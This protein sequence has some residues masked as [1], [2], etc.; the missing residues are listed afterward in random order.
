MAKFIAENIDKEKKLVDRIINNLHK[1]ENAYITIFVAH[2]SKSNYLLD[3]LL[4]NAEILFEEYKPATLDS[5]ELSFFDQHED[6]II[7]AVLPA[8]QNSV[9]EERSK[10]L[11]EK[12]KREDVRKESKQDFEEDKVN[13]TSELARELRR[14]IKTVEVMGLVIK[15]RAGSLDKNRLEHLFEQGLKVHLRILSSFFEIIK[16][17]NFEDDFVDFITERL[18]HIIKS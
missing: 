5:Q 17:K 8:Y 3:E 10:L 12:A 15:N 14:S 13:E 4:L 6:K 9:G 11:V 1:D 2:H 7:K 16:N 18:N